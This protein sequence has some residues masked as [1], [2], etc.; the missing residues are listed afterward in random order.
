[1]ASQVPPPQAQ[2]QVS[3]PSPQVCG[4]QSTR[5]APPT[6]AEQISPSAQ[7][8]PWQLWSQALVVMVQEPSVQR[9]STMTPPASQRS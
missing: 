1:V 4:R 2:S 6:W 3:G 5:R 8:V 9:A 7:V